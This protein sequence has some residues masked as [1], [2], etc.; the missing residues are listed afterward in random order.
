MASID[1]WG[2]LRT[3]EIK[4]EKVSTPY[5]HN[6]SKEQWRKWVACEA[7]GKVAITTNGLSMDE[8][9]TKL[10]LRAYKLADAFLKEGD[11]DE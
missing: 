1:E 2:F 4:I 10:S 8:V 3:K 11:R 9:M 5:P 6:M 7:L